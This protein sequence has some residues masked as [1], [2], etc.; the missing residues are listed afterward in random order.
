MIQGDQQVSLLIPDFQFLLFTSVSCDRTTQSPRT[1][2]PL[3]GA[4]RRE[5]DVDPREWGLGQT[6]RPEAGARQ[7]GDPHRAATQST[8]PCQQSC[9]SNAG[10]WAQFPCKVCSPQKTPASQ[11]CKLRG[12]EQGA[13]LAG[14]QHWMRVG[15]GR[16]PHS[17]ACGHITPSQPPCS[18][19]PPNSLRSLSLDMCTLPWGPRK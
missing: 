11:G 1:E 17:Q 12:F 3:C 15:A 8:P 9:G 7:C 10:V 18:P 5:A 14:H 6:P 19:A 2:Q 16:S 4:H 13:R